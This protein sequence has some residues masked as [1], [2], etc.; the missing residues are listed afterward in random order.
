[1]D[2]MTQ[3]AYRR[4]VLNTARRFLYKSRQDADQRLRW[5]RAQRILRSF[6]RF[7]F[8]FALEQY[9]HFPQTHPVSQIWRSAEGDDNNQTKYHQQDVCSWKNIATT[10]I[11]AYKYA[12]L[13]SVGISESQFNTSWEPNEAIYLW[14]HYGRNFSVFTRLRLDRIEINSMNNTASCSITPYITLN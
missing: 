4:S 1:M 13:W 3:I 9:L 2:N 11:I 12:L 8:T 7:L 14:G 6:C 5:C 10:I